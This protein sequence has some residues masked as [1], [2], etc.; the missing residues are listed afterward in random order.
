[1]WG[2]RVFCAKVSIENSFQLFFSFWR[3]C[4]W[5]IKTRTQEIIGLVHKCCRSNFA[6]LRSPVNSNIFFLR[7]ATAFLSK[8]CHVSLWMITLDSIHLYLKIMS[9]PKTIFVLFAKLNITYENWTNYDWRLKSWE[10]FKFEKSVI[11]HDHDLKGARF[12]K[13]FKSNL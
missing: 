1:M 10:N 8:L 12:T 11:L 4:D 13:L 6:N 2:W 3:L 9:P 7:N 5:P